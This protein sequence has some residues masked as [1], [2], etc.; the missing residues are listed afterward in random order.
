MF[1]KAEVLWD[2]GELKKA[3]E[4]LE[5]ASKNCTL[6]TDKLNEYKQ[7]YEEAH[8]L[9]YGDSKMEKIE[10]FMT[11]MK[12][13]GAIFNKIQMRYYGVDYRG[14]H[15]MKDL[16]EGEVFLTVPEN[17]IIT[18]QKGK[19]TPIGA[20]VAKANLD[21]SWDYLI[22]ITIFLLTQ[23]HDPN[24]SWK[25]YIEVYPKDVSSFPIYYT[26][27]ERELLKGSVMES[28]IDDEI[29]EMKEEY[30]KITEAVPEFKEFTLDEYIKNKTLIISRIFY[31][32][33]HGVI[34]RIMVPLADMFN[35][36]YE[37][38]GDT[39]WRYDNEEDSF[40]V[41]A[42]KAIPKGDPICEHY[43]EKP[44]Y[45]FL[46]YYGFLIEN[47]TRNC[48]YVKLYLNKD[49]LKVIQ[50]CNMIGAYADVEIKS[51]KYFEYYDIEEAH[52]NKF[53]S[54]LR[55]IEYEGDLSLFNNYLTPPIVDPSTCDFV[56]RKLRCPILSLEN[57]RKVLV[58]MKQI[59]IECLK[60]YPDTYEKDM[61]LLNN[62]D[63]TFNQRNCI[64]L[65]AGEK[66]IFNDMI[67]LAELGIELI[68]MN[69]AKKVQEHFEK[70]GKNKTYTGYFWK[71][72]MPFIVLN[73]V[74][75]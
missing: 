53:F 22:Y 66:K 56:K 33:M 68:D 34:D 19:E 27:E 38:L 20:K 57:E 47:N 11:W 23:F 7:L 64:I 49:C 17:L 63:L 61:E 26:K 24:S 70:V 21:L 48:V 13:N 43:G 55:F 69:D 2:L 52:N 46:F 32:T 16:T 51:F 25:P 42:E 72:L 54:Y 60:G 30:N 39:R 58:K 73:S 15:T 14:V 37:R 50:K 8:C 18:A 71:V 74:P 4:Y 6:A 3:I 62:K 12:E 1:T 75:N 5:E 9:P 44:N 41:S 36:H 59:A 40:V 31:V 35:H 67:V 10:A 29:E 45:R 65:R 28:H